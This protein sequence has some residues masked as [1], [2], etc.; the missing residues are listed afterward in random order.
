MEIR[1]TILRNSLNPESLSI[2]ERA[3]IEPGVK[4]DSYLT[5]YQFERTGYFNVDK[6]SSDR[7][8]VFNR[9]VSLKDS[10]KK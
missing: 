8:M 9:T 1:K 6:D 3:Y 10:W 5:H 2:I 4:G 7:K